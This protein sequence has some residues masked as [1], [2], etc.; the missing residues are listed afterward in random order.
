MTDQLDQI[1]RL[2]RFNLMLA[3]IWSLDELEDACRILGDK[4]KSRDLSQFNVLVLEAICSPVLTKMFILGMGHE[5]TKLVETMLAR[6]IM[7]TVYSEVFQDMLSTK[8]DGLYNIEREEEAKVFTYDKT[9]KKEFKA[10]LR[11]LLKTDADLEPAVPKTMGFSF[12]SISGEYIWGD[13]NALRLLERKHD[14]MKGSNLFK[15]MIPYSAHYLSQRFGKKLFK[16]D[17]KIGSTLCFSFVIYSKQA[18]NK[19]IKQIRNKKIKKLSDVQEDSNKKTVY[20][21]F[22]KSLS[23]RATLVSLQYSKDDLEKCVKEV[24]ER[25]EATEATPKETSGRTRRT[26]AAND[27]GARET[28]DQPVQISVML[29]MRTSKSIPDFD[30]PA[31]EEDPKIVEFKNYIRKRLNDS[32]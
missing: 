21:K 30:Y 32:D 28:K 22:L 14:Q 27:S 31:M 16:K 29:E 6:N 7:P 26:R 18:V 12:F 1:D 8:L 11:E 15:Q 5:G 3:S 20:F 23:C 13:G 9:A 4:L 25:N 10:S 19:Y 24:K 17:A 2:N